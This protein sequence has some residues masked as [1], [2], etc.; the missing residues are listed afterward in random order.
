MPRVSMDTVQFLLENSADPNKTDVEAG[1]PLY[2]VAHPDFN[3]PEIRN[4][5]LEIV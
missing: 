1:T 2:Y 3:P 4:T 5:P